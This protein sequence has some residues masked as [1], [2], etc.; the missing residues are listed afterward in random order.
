MDLSRERGDIARRRAAHRTSL[1]PL[2]AALLHGY[3]DQTFVHAN[4]RRS[5]SSNAG[6][7]RRRL[8][9]FDLA[10]SRT[11]RETAR[12]PAETLFATIDAA[13]RKSRTKRLRWACAG[14]LRRGT[15]VREVG[16]LVARY[17]GKRGEHCRSLWC[18]IDRLGALVVCARR[19]NSTCSQDALTS[20]VAPPDPKE[21][22]ARGRGTLAG[23]MRARLRKSFACAPS[24]RALELQHCCRSAA[25]FPTCCRCFP[26]IGC[27]F[28]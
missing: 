23:M 5:A 24:R 21:R 22:Q 8:A 4:P 13:A 11:C 10:W 19:R 17:A 7:P 12:P 2:A 3:L 25:S 6:H 16:H 20:R 1:A 27:N 28:A 18:C 26:R 15:F 14:G 9:I